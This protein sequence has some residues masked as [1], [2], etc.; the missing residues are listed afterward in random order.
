MAYSF[1][2]NVDLV[3]RYLGVG[4]HSIP[5]NQNQLSDILNDFSIL[6]SGS[7]YEVTVNEIIP[8]VVSYIGKTESTVAKESKETEVSDSYQRQTTNTTGKDAGTGSFTLTANDIRYTVIYLVE[9][10]EV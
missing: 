10:K 6:S 3:S 7:E 4:L 8:V 1:F 5:V 9:T 2:T